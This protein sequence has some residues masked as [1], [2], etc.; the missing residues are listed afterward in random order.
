MTTTDLIQTAGGNATLTTS[1]AG[2]LTIGTAGIKTSLDQ[3]SDGGS[4]RITAANTTGLGTS[5]FLNGELNTEGGTGGIITIGGGVQMNVPPVSGAGNIDVNGNSGALILNDNTYNTSTTFN[6]S[7]QDI[8]INGLQETTGVGSDLTFFADFGNTGVGGVRVCTGGIISSGNL[9]IKGSDLIINPGISIELQPGSL[10]QAAGTISSC[11][12]GNSD[13][14]INR[15]IES[16]GA[17]QDV[18]ITPA[19]TVKSC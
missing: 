4:I 2:T 15:N 6:V 3:I 18:T 7:A 16:T 5:V 11:N 17:S 12:V 10:I 13:I 8:I 9:T 14:F 19:G 1:G